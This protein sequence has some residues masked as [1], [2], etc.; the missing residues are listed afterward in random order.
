MYFKVAFN[1]AFLT[2][3]GNLVTS[4]I[5]PGSGIKCDA[6]YPNSPKLSNALFSTFKTA[7]KNLYKTFP[8]LFSE[9]YAPFH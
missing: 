6:S 3:A 7:L 1:H 2:S 4:A 8:I 9:I 5:L